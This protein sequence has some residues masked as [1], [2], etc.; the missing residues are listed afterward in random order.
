MPCPAG[1]P[2]NNCARMVPMM[3]RG[4]VAPWVTPEKQAE[5]ARIEQC[6]DCGQCIKK[7]PYNLNTPQL[8][9]QNLEGYNKILADLGLK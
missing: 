3:S 4:P 7:C 2:I 6:L 5:M 1:I 8:L 9:R